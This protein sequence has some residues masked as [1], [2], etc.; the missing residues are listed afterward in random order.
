MALQCPAE[1]PGSLKP[2]FDFR[3]VFTRLPKP[4]GKDDVKRLILGLHERLWHA[5]CQGIQSI[6]QRCGM[7]HAVWRLTSD[8]VASCRICR[9]FAALVAVLNIEVL[10]FTVDE[11]TRINSHCDRLPES[12][13]IER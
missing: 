5:G 6:L 1:H 11:A 12:R 2:I 4:A 8:A 10:T 13:D 3:R 9:R 7:P